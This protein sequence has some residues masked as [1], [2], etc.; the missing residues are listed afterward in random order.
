MISFVVPIYNVENYLPRC[1]DS[2][3]NQTI[4]DIE[5]LLV[6]DGSPDNCSTICDSYLKKDS[7]VRVLHKRNEGVSKARNM[8]LEMALGEY[9]CFVD[10][11]DWLA[12]DF[13]EY[14]IKLISNG[15]SDFALSINNFTS[16]NLG[17]IYKDKIE[18]WP[19]EKIIDWF[20]SYRI[21]I[22]CWNKIYRKS[23]LK[24]F[25]LSFNEKYIS[26]EGLLFI[27][28]AAK[29]AGNICI[30]RRK[31]YIYNIDNMTSATTSTNMLF[32]K[33]T[34]RSLSAIRKALVNCNNKVIVACDYYEYTCR[35]LF[36]CFLIRSKTHKFKNALYQKQVEYIKNNGFRLLLKSHAPVRH[37]VS[38]PLK[39]IS[40]EINYRLANIMRRIIEDK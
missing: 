11:D 15:N 10:S 18:I 32:F 30:G 27:I 12:P 17:Q 13:A 21:T 38:M 9:V 1:I 36:L 2:I 19:S 5:I 28:E 14:M 24:K 40:P 35:Y 31:I 8:G 37:K 20:L 23:F 26:G 33:N 6:D 25:N 29:R 4:E 22:G 16:Q 3:L 34:F 7:R 39:C